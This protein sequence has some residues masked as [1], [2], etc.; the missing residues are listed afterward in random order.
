MALALD[1]FFSFR[2]PYSYLSVP[3]IVELQ[4]EHELDVTVR[5][6]LP[7]AVRDDT[8]FERVNPLWPPYLVRD[9]VRLAEYLGMGFHWPRP[10]PIVQEFPSRKVAAEQPHIHRLS[11]LGVLAAEAGRGL[12]CIQ[13][14]SQII[15]NGEVEGWNEGSH[16]S[17]AFTRAGLDL[18]ELDRRAESESERLDAVIEDNQ[19]ALASAGHWG[20][21]TFVFDGEP[22]FGQ[23]RIELLIWRLKQA[24]LQRRQS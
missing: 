6:V 12:P 7:L 3:R 24:G 2:S 10:D 22:F 15:W 20:V 19:A 18:A 5:I 14:V 13:E 21:P 4:R 23:D 9:C 16:L 17:D 1:Y 8:F 11:R